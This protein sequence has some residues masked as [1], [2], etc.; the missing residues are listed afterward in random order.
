MPVDSPLA[1]AVKESRRWR[2]VYDDGRAI[3]FRPAG[4]APG[5]VEQYSTSSQGGIG[6]RDLAVTAVTPKHVNP[7]DHVIQN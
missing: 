6:G 4:E 3:V 5:R 1:G 2:A 7:E